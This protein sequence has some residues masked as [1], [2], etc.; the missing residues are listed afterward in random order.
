MFFFV[1]LAFSSS[2]N[3]SLILNIDPNTG[4]LIGASNIDV[5]GTFYDVLFRE[6]SIEEIFS[7]LHSFD[8]SSKEEADLFSLAL[9]NQLFSQNPPSGYDYNP[10]QI[11][12]CSYLN[13]CS[14]LAPYA[15]DNTNTYTNSSG[16]VNQNGDSADFISLFLGLYD[17]SDSSLLYSARVDWKV[18]ADWTLSTPV[19]EPSSLLLFVC[20]ILGLSSRR[21][22]RHKD[23]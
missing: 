20:A 18:Y 13:E 8:A 15:V 11:F 5:N 10:D 12:G 9:L 2:A 1:S 19:P 23:N 14:I 7:P 4:E 16:V 22:F 17:F 21:L 3:A 6:G